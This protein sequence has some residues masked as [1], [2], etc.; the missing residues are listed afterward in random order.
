M[1][2]DMKLIVAFH[3]YA[4]APKNASQRTIRYLRGSTV[5]TGPTTITNMAVT[6]KFEA[7]RKHIQNVYSRDKFST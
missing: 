5:V 1:R 6:L 7:K 4:N 3:N 2:T